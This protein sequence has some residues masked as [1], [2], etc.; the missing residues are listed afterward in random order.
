M[1]IGFGGRVLETGE[2]K[3]L[4]S[5]ETPL[6]AKGRELYG[7][8]QAR[9]ALRE[10]G[11]VV[12]VEGYMDV[13]ALAQSGIEYAVATL[14]TA[15]T[16]EHVQKLMR[17]SDEIVFCF[18][19]DGAGRRAAWRALENAL[20]QLQD[21]KQV[22]FLF[23]P[24]GEDPDTFVRKKGKIAFEESLVTDS[25]TLSAF[26]KQHLC[27][28][29]DLRMPEGRAAL[30]ESARPLLTSISAPFLKEAMIQDFARLGGVDAATLADKVG[31]KPMKAPT[32]GTGSRFQP[33]P[34]QSRAHNN[35]KT[36]LAALIARPELV[37]QLDLEMEAFSSDE[38][39]AFLRE[40]VDFLRSADERST[41]ASLIQ[42]FSDG[43]YDSNIREI[44]QRL[45]SPE[46]GEGFDIEAEFRDALMKIKQI[47]K[48]ETIRPLIAQD[49]HK[50]WTPDEAATFSTWQNS[51]DGSR[52]KAS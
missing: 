9:R 37:D 42:H 7:L 4:N 47:Q 27:E 11:R 32:T 21:G 13:V 19:G 49:P 6:F 12:V 52:V 41:S 17:Q 10:A 24:E 16:P 26:M 34:R 8:Y 2:P 30:L 28:G 51:K 33:Q 44:T 43:R 35:E 25:I 5:P 50:K 3:Y 38:I 40:V 14:G 48:D 1:V 22:K 23:L 39:P 20:A 29:I 31:S 18:D 36:V 45:A 46:W 15:T